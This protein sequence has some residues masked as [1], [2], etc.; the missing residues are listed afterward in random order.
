MAQVSIQYTADISQLNSKL[1]EIIRKQDQ[2]IDGSKKTEKSISDASSK[3]ADSLNKVTSSLTKVG[4]ALG[5]AFSVKQIIEFTKNVFE[6]ERSMELLQNRLNFF[7]G[8]AA[9]GEQMFARLEA[10]SRRLGLNLNDTAEGLASFGI[11]AKQAGFSAQKSEKIFVQVA[12]GLRAAGASSL[13]TQRAFYALQQMMSKGV[14]AAEELRR[15]LGESLPGASDLMTKAYNRLHPAANL[16]NLEFTKLLESGKIISKEILPVFAQVIEETFAPALSGKKNSLDASLNKVNN[17]ILKLKLNIGN[18]EWF[19]AALDNIS[20]GMFRLNATLESEKLTNLQK[21]LVL[22]P[23]LLPGPLSTFAK[24]ILGTSKDIQVAIDEFN[25]NIEQ[26]ITTNKVFGNALEKQSEKYRNISVKERE[27]R[28]RNTDQQIEANEEIIKSNNKNLKEYNKLVEEKKKQY[29]EE[30]KAQTVGKSIHESTYIQIELTKKYHKE[31]KDLQKSRSKDE[32]IS[33]KQIQDAESH[34]EFLKELRVAFYNLDEE[35]SNKEKKRKEEADEAEKQRLKDALANAKKFHLEQAKGSAEEAIAAADVA[36]KQMELDVFM[37]KSK[38]EKDLARTQGAIKSEKEI[39][40]YQREAQ[41]KSLEDQIAYEKEKLANAEKGSQEELKIKSK[42][43]L[44]EAKLRATQAGLTQQQI[45][46]ILAEASAAVVDLTK[47]FD[48]AAK[49]AADA[50]EKNKY[51]ISRGIQDPFL[52]ATAKE[53]ENAK[54][55]YADLFRL[56]QENLDKKLISWEEYTQTVKDLQ[57][58][59]QRDIENITKDGN[60]KQSKIDADI[61]NQKLRDIQIIAN[62]TF[63]FF[64]SRLNL[65]AELARAAVDNLDSLLQ[66][67]MIT[68][69][70][71]EDQKAV[72]MREQFEK[73]KSLQISRA[74]M[75]GAAAILNIIGNSTTFKLAPILIPLAVAQTA[76]QLS[77]IEAQVPAFK[78][79]VINLQGPGT[80]KSDSITAMLSKGESVMTA[81]ETEKYGDVLQSIRNGTFDKVSRDRFLLVVLPFI[82]PTLQMF[83]AL[84]AASK[85][86]NRDAQGFKDGVIGLNG[87]GTATSDSIM[88]RLSKGESV[89][90][91]EETN[92]HRDV[93]QAIREDRLPSLI[94]EKYMIPA[95][96]NSLDVPRSTAAEST[97]M[98]VA[99]QTAELVQ[100]IKSNKKIKIANVEDF[101]KVMNSKSTSQYM[102]RRRKW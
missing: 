85:L 4:A 87:P 68:Q 12:S 88:A 33:I 48:D 6:A 36:K 101:S 77:L 69:K 58:G 29:L 56:N 70:Q 74:I 37:A 96:K 44:L 67:G 97:S 17:E 24:S 92:K 15:Q 82:I 49:A 83:G 52:D 31:I 53:I 18:A 13:Q 27:E 25:N 23:S 22:L 14:V 95:Y 99:F 47:K 59:L 75:N 89:M 43:I 32:Q 73:E 71:Y 98:E 28:K 38:A 2:I 39:L 84:M 57:R 61:L 54:K 30:V 102:A 64:D 11:A 63:D 10:T 86:S 62:A 45:D 34:N 65:E 3:S 76:Q 9:S 79:G 80:S 46:T 42:V 21:F 55:H 94:A 100:A 7:A 26:A 1:D 66:K 5:I 72:L 91:A 16:T 78:D 51:K 90:T 40:E 19:K 50:F 8:S 60:E 81:E 35:L 41:K 20:E 93:L